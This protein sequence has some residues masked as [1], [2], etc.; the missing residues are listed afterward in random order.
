[1]L[2]TFTAGA[3][4]IQYKVG[5][6]LEVKW[7]DSWYTAKILEIKNG[8]YTVQYDVDGA[9]NFVQHDRMRPL[10]G[11]TYTS[12]STNQTRSQTNQTDR[13]TNTT[14]VQY[15]PGD[16]V[17]VD[18]AGINAWEKGTIMPFLKNDRQDGKT[19]RVRLD[20]STG[21]YLE[22]VFVP[23]DRIRKQSA[24]A[25][26]KYE[27][28]QN[29]NR[30]LYQKGSR[31]EVFSSN[32]WYKGEI[33]AADGDRYRVHYDGYTETWDEWVEASRLRKEQRAT[34][35]TTT[36]KEDK[37]QPD[38]GGNGL[39]RL[40]GTGWSTRLIGEKGQA[41]Q[42]QAPAIFNFCKSGKW[43][44]NRGRTIGEIGTYKVAGNTVAI[45]NS[46]DKRTT[47]YAMKWEADNQLLVLTNG[48]FVMKFELV[49]KN[50]CGER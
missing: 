49:T 16:R 13:A 39:P 33:I 34:N 31:V 47:T 38:F 18:K 27:Q 8:W 10:K 19:Y 32:K 41:T 40:A 5:D 1:L 35:S 20:A 2:A 6:K 30:Q 17:E 37:L 43:S 12:N 36:T 48:S 21:V 46:T 14:A 4:D 7:A 50:A 24:E 28:E 22:G 11:Y 25:Q 45:T 9:K 29:T 3:Q 44:V 26:K 42:P 23:V 15:K